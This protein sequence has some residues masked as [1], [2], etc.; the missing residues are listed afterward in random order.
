MRTLWM[1]QEQDMN[2]AHDIL[3]SYYDETEDEVELEEVTV[4]QEGSLLV[5][6]AEWVVDLEETMEARYGQKHGEI[7]AARVMTLLLAEGAEI[8]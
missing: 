1:T 2:I 3:A 6:R 5:A 4:T 7:V 8:H